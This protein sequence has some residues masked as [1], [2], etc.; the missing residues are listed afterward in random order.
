HKRAKV[1][2]TQPVE[3]APVPVSAPERENETTD[4]VVE[5]EDDTEEEQ[6]EEPEL[7]A[8]NA[9]QNIQQEMKELEGE[10]P[11]TENET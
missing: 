9:I 3:P 7:P 8:V 1:D 5:I 6:P 10:E 2:A 11:E 4:D